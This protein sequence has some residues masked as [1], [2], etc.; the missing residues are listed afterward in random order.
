M[1]LFE[2]YVE[3]RRACSCQV[4]YLPVTSMAKFWNS[5]LFVAALGQVHAEECC[6]R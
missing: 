4:F 3:C 1:P 6:R 5:A 2:L